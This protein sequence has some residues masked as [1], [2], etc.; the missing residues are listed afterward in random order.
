MEDKLLRK[1]NTQDAFD[2]DVYCFWCVGCGCGHYFNSSWSLTGTEDKPTV[3]PSLLVD[4]DD[5]NRRCHLFIRDGQIQY[6]SDCHH[7]L[8]GKTI[9][10]EAF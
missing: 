4:K 1:L 5:P 10:M 2:Q 6:L 7:E 8:A 9:P 3:N